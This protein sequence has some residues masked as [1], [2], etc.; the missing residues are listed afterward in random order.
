MGK[1]NRKWEVN[2]QFGKVSH[3]GRGFRVESDL[4]P[5]AERVGDRVILFGLRMIA[6][7]AKEKTA[8]IVVSRWPE[9]KPFKGDGYDYLTAVLRQVGLD[10]ENSTGAKYGRQKAI[11]QG[12][13]RR[14]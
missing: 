4:A 9:A 11:R 3:D 1:S 10:V 12:A 14:R 6:I 2:T 8:W 7:G 13:Q 5:L